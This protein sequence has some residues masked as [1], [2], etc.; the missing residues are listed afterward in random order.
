V[1]LESQHLKPNRRSRPDLLVYDAAARRFLTDH[2]IINPIASSRSKQPVHKSL[3][4]VDKRK[5]SNYNDMAARIG[6]T[7]VPLVFSA[8]G[9]IPDTAH[10]FLA[11]VSV[12]AS[13]LQ[14]NAWPSGPQGLCRAMLASVSCATQKR[15][16]HIIAIAAQRALF[17]AR[18][19]IAVAVP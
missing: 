16:A 14:M 2:T 13:E 1:N 7:F 8:L 18:R 12:T 15:N 3:E 11:F 10:N 9:H 17:L 6:A 5:R 4:Q 19:G